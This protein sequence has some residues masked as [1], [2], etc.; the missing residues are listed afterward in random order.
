MNERNT[1]TGISNVGYT[2]RNISRYKFGLP[3]NAT[4]K[5]AGTSGTFNIFNS[6]LLQWAMTET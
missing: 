5:M 4:D 2:T 1:E 6:E 3:E